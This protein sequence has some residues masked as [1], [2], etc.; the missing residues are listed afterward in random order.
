MKI[1][2]K[3]A[4]GP[5]T[6]QDPNTKYSLKLVEKVEVSPDT[7]RFVFALPSE[8]LAKN[9]SLLTDNLNFSHILG[10][11]VGQHVYV[12]ARVELFVTNIL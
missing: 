5:I 2:V 1:R 7:R 12:S 8:K 4:K 6:L 11:P 10:L 9:S 3:P